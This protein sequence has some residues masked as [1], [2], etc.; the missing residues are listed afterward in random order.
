MFGDSPKR[1][2]QTLRILTGEGERREELRLPTVVRVG[3]VQ[4]IVENLATVDHGKVS[5]TELHVGRIVPRRLTR[6]TLR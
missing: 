2:H 3:F 4:K 5:V 1:S 6:P